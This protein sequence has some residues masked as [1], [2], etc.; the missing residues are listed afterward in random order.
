MKYLGIVLLFL[1]SNVLGETDNSNGIYTDSYQ[2]HGGYRWLDADLGNF[3]SISYHDVG[4]RASKNIMDIGLLNIYA[5]YTGMDSN[6][7]KSESSGLTA[8]FVL[9]LSKYFSTSFSSSGWQYTQSNPYKSEGY[10]ISGDVFLHDIDYGKIGVQLSYSD[11]KSKTNKIS[12]NSEMSAYT[13]Y[14]SYYFD[15][16]TVN[17]IT[18]LSEIEI[19]NS[20]VSNSNA[21]WYVSA[22]LYPLDNTKLTVQGNIIDS[23]KRFN[24]TLNHQIFDNLILG[25]QFE[26]QDDLYHNGVIGVGSQTN[27]FTVNT[28][29]FNLIYHFG[30]KSSMKSRDRNLQQ[31]GVYR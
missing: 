14:G 17:A 24:A 25:F 6:Y 3:P 16:F 23:N 1:S 9:P 4:A 20:S 31:T 12:W 10:T 13:L 15:D 22:N 30:N 8:A 5:D 29:G 18:Y 27:R 28:Y 11:A 19:G 21:L 7:G 26:I 2:V